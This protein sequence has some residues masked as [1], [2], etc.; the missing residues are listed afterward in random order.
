MS[1]PQIIILADYPTPEIVEMHIRRAHHLRAIA[2]ARWLRRGRQAVNGLFTPR[3]AS[4]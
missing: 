3:N 4:P 1:G 2:Y